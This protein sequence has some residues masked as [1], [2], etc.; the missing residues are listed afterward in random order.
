MS[1][2][3]PKTKKLL[4]KLVAD[5]TSRLHPDERLFNQNDKHAYIYN[6]FNGNYDYS[7]TQFKE[8]LGYL[9]NI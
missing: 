8:L 7:V 6:L 5:Y 4:D 9:N 3:S 1:E 2:L